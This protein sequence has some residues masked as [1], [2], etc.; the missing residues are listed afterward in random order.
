LVPSIT[1]EVAARP[2]REGR[3]RTFPI[4]LY[5]MLEQIELEGR[6]DIIAWKP[7]GCTFQVLKIE[8]FEELVLPRYA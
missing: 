4:I 1:M 6:A 2:K 7:H 3:Q 5:A 8:E